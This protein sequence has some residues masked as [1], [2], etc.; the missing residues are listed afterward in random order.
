MLTK[1]LDLVAILYQL[2]FIG[3]F[4]ETKAPNKVLRAT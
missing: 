1:Q 4:P 2:L 3:P